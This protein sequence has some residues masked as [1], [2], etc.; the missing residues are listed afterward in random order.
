MIR[1]LRI[2]ETECMQRMKG[3]NDG[4]MECL[5][6]RLF[7][8]G[9]SRGLTEVDMRMHMHMHAYTPVIPICSMHCLNLGPG[10]GL[11]RAS[12]SIHSVGMYSR[13]MAPVSMHSLMK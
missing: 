13:H 10:R 11:V 3:W 8:T 12:A 9:K 4:R 1:M 7:F 6:E 2:E 5:N